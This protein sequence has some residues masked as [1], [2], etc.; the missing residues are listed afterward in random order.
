MH[1][2]CACDAYSVRV[3][4]VTLSILG[5]TASNFWTDGSS[6][7]FSKLSTPL[8]DTKCSSIMQT[9]GW[10]MN[11]CN[12]QKAVLC[13]RGIVITIYRG[14]ELYLHGMFM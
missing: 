3:N 11:D 1:F 9:G 6:A 2:T 10:I 8:T 13:K 7:A 12:E 4:T 5:L 14:E